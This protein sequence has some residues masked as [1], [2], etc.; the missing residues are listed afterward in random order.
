MRF[1]SWE[2]RRDMIAMRAWET[3]TKN[4]NRLDYDMRFQTEC[5]ARDAV[6]NTYRDEMTDEQ[7]LAATMRRLNGR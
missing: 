7:W 6:T 5:T 4:G 1:Q 3:W 2:D